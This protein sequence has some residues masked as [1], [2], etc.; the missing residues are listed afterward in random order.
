[1]NS[2]NFAIKSLQ[3]EHNIA[4]QVTNLF[5]AAK[6]VKKIEDKTRFSFLS[7][8]EDS[9]SG[10]IHPASVKHQRLSAKD[11]VVTGM[12]KDLILLSVRRKNRKDLKVCC[13]SEV[14]IELKA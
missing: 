11:H 5:G 10:M 7:N 8:I 6:T 12:S 3:A 1:M 4:K 2:K 14:L 13:L 9:K